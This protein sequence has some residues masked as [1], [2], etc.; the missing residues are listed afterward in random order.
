MINFRRIVCSSRNHL[1]PLRWLMLSAAPWCADIA[2]P[3]NA[4]SFAELNPGLQAANA[5]KCTPALPSLYGAALGEEKE[6]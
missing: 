1:L 3:K 6:P 4:L 5:V 2:L